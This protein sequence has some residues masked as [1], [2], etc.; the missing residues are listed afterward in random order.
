MGT[1]IFVYGRKGFVFPA[2]RVI[3]F[4]CASCTLQD[5]PLSLGE[6][7]QGEEFSQQASSQDG[8]SAMDTLLLVSAVC[9]PDS[10]DWQRD[11]AY[12][13]V[14]CTLKLFGNGKE[15][16]SV[17]GGP[18]TGVSAAFDGHHIIGTSLYTV[19]SDASGTYVGRDGERILHWPERE[20][21][22]GLLAREDGLYTL[23]TGLDGALNLRCDGRSMLSV[24]GGIAFGGFGVDTYGPNGSL[25]EDAGAICFAYKVKTGNSWAVS[26]VE[27]GT[28]CDS[29]TVRPRCS[30]LDARRIRGRNV[31]LFDDAGS[32]SISVDGSIRNITQ[33]VGVSWM[34]AV[35]VE[36]G[37]EFSALGTCDILAVHRNGYGV[38]NAHDF[39][40][41]EG[42]PDYVY[43]NGGDFIPL[44]SDSYPDCR[45]FG[46]SCGAVLY[47]EPAIA[48]TPKDGVS[49]PYVL[50][51][52]RRTEYPVH[53]FLSGVSFKL[54]D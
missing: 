27:D 22:S 49:N 53:G 7:R 36:W 12:G 31:V 16:L 11:T 30:A 9:F 44:C 34:D 3:L 8:I 28:V 21:I 38:G 51:K 50:Y 4:L 52:G 6:P 10:Y 20:V 25:Y 42:P 47:G 54:P 37:G 32:T 1:S 23:G 41:I 2:L 46:R 18:G 13:K 29:L 45:F 24:P 39:R 48:L 43:I 17:S 40:E 33:T 35:I 14:P 5:P 26:I 19:Y 15:L